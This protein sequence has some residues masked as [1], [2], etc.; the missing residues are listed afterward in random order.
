MG[1][2]HP[3]ASQLWLGVLG[4]TRYQGFDPSP[5]NHQLCAK[6]HPSAASP[7]RLRPRGCAPRPRPEAL[8]GRP[9]RC[10]TSGCASQWLIA[11]Y[12]FSHHPRNW[13]IHIFIYI[14][15]PSIYIYRTGFKLDDSPLT[16]KHTKVPVQWHILS[17]CYGGQLKFVSN[18]Y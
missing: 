2:S 1:Y 10:R 5:F 9:P 4:F 18:G 6:L 16:G 7:C 11:C 17:F 15:I 14:Y 13:N 3:F 12:N 8:S